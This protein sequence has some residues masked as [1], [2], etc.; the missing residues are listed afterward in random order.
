MNATPTD[1][2]LIASLLRQ[3]VERTD[4]PREKNASIRRLQRVAFGP[5]S[6]QRH[7]GDADMRAA[8]RRQEARG[9]P[10]TFSTAMSISQRESRLTK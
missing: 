4:L 8:V 10:T 9:R 1:A 6:E 3:Y 2:P 5:S 7:R